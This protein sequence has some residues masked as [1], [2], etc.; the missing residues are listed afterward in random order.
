MYLAEA[1]QAGFNAALLIKKELDHEKH[2]EE[3]SWDSVHVVNCAIS[4]DNKATYTLTSTVFITM[5]ANIQALGKM[6]LAGSCAN[7]RVKKDV[8]LNAQNPNSTHIQQIG[9]MIEAIED[10]MRT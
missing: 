5:D 7:Q 10:V 6:S 1:E 2:I 8:P 9:M 3:T 4:P